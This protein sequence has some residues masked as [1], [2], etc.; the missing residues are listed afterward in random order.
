[1][2][3]SNRLKLGHYFNE[4]VAIVVLHTVHAGV[5][6]SWAFC[7]E[8][9]NYILI[10]SPMGFAYPLFLL[11]IPLT[12]TVSSDLWILSGFTLPS[13]KPESKQYTFA[14]ENQWWFLKEA[15]HQDYEGD[16]CAEVIYVLCKGYLFGPFFC[17]S[18]FN[19][20]RITSKP[21]DGFRWLPFDGNSYRVAILVG[22]NYF[23]SSIST[24]CPN[25]DVILAHIPAS[26]NTAGAN[27]LGPN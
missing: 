22:L 15:L 2:A 9:P 10:W 13:G 14:F 17:M 25:I 12:F 6:Q 1:M 23:C 11:C 18:T 26:N 24:S 5:F 8:S 3:V 16:V 21:Y 7:V 27:F 19:C 20:H 4:F